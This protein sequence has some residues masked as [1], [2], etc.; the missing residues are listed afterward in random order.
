[1]AERA[2]VAIAQGVHLGT[3][4]GLHRV[5]VEFAEAARLPALLRFFFRARHLALAQPRDHRLALM[6]APHRDPR[7]VP[8]AQCDMVQRHARGQHHLLEVRTLVGARAVAH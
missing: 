1:M 5:A 2:L 7:K 4:N 8:L 6:R 3:V